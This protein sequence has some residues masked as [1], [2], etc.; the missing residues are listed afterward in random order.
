MPGVNNIAH[1]GGFIGGYAAGLVLSLAERRTE[2]TLDWLLASAAIAVTAIGFALALF[3][4]FA[5]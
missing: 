3:T 4:A 1:A 2:S 5:G